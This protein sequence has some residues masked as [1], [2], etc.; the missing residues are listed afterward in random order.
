MHNT[1]QEVKYY[2]YR[3]STHTSIEF[4]N[5]ERLILYIQKGNDTQH[6]GK[7]KIYNCYLEQLSMNFKDVSH[8][9]NIFSGEI[10][11][12]PKEYLVY[13]E[14]FRIIDTRIYKNLIF[15]LHYQKYL[16]NK[17]ENTPIKSTC[18][19]RRDR[20][21][22]YIYRNTP[23]PYTRKTKNKSTHKPKVRKEIRNTIG[24]KKNYLRN[25]R[26][27]T[28]KNLLYLYD[29]DYIYYRNKS[30]RCWKNQSKKKKQW[31]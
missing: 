9:Y 12:Y 2:L 18:K 17:Y 19:Y 20:K 8:V 6:Y 4:K 15:N 10:E 21:K 11:C 26:I 24:V 25:S 3:A 22:I 13:D 28:L 29:W 14:N 5:F 1:K 7:N 31:M 23:V 16:Q 27:T 30:I